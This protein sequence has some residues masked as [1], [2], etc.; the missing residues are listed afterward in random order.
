MAL[1]KQDVIAQLVGKTHTLELGPDKLGYAYYETTSRAY[2]LLPDAE[3]PMRGTWAANDGGY[4][5]D[6][7]N[8]PSIDWTL[9]MAGDDLIYIRDDGTK[10]AKVVASAS[11]DD[12]G[13]KAHF[14]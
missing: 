5:C 7:E 4:H 2:I 8:G 11:G 14:A 12:A 1:S 13:L 3:K 10:A 6:W 9:E